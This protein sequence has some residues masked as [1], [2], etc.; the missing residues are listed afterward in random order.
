MSG[1]FTGYPDWFSLYL[2]E[3]ADRAKA[4]RERAYV[5][6]QGARNA[7]FNALQ[8]DARRIALESGLDPEL[9]TSAKAGIGNALKA[10]PLENIRTLLSEGSAPSTAR[11]NEYMN[12]YQKEVVKRIGKLGGRNLRENLLPAINTSFTKAGQFGG[13]RHQKFLQKALRQSQESTLAKQQEALHQGYTT[14]LGAS[15][16]SRQRQLGAANIGGRTAELTAQRQL[17]AGRGAAELAQQE[18]LGNLRYGETIGGL[19]HQQQALEQEIMDQKYRDFLEQQ[20]YPAERTQ[21]FAN[22]VR[23]LPTSTSSIQRTANPVPPRPSS[24]SQFAS[25]AAGVLGAGGLGFAEGGPVT[26]EEVQG[27]GSILS[28]GA[29]EAKRA[30]RREQI[31]SYADELTQAPQMNKQ[32]ALWELLARTGFAMG[33][34]RN[35]DAF[36]AFSEGA[37]SGLE[38]LQAARAQAAE[39]RMRGFNLHNTLDVQEIDPVQK[40]EE[41]RLKHQQQQELEELKGAQALGLA[42]EKFARESQLPKNKI[43]K[44]AAGNFTYEEN[45]ETGQ[46]ELV[47]ISGAPDLQAQKIEQEAAK[48][49]LKSNRKLYDETI[50]A[51]K[52]AEEQLDAVKRLGQLL[53]KPGVRRSD[54]RQSIIK[55]GENIGIHV[56]PNANEQEIDAISKEILARN[57]ANLRGGGRGNQVEFEQALRATPGIYTHPESAERILEQYNKAAKKSIMLKKR[58]QE[59]NKQYKGNF[60]ATF[61][62]LLEQPSPEEIDSQIESLQNQL[63]N[64]EGEELEGEQDDL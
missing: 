31:R 39:N 60:P 37:L 57:F 61:D 19:G 63:N 24:T 47:P 22:L 30:A 2:K 51:G 42:E 44:T 5:P 9:L 40:M 20:R 23:G 27:I 35:P 17:Q 45:P 36:G 28:R 14:A 18:Q 26:G 3:A 48:T 25:L 15:E 21:E 11:I 8:L 34:S 64:Y 16:A 10:K 54:L 46:M 13:S 56:S 55:L 7:P 53:N 50:E 29:D 1:V 49:S 41:L 33:A 12:P 59:L 62:I 32:R 43:V 52:S 58:A 6:Y 38:G 4:E